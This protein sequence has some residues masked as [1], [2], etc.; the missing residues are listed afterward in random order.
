[1][2]FGSRWIS[3]AEHSRSSFALVVS[4][5]CRWGSSTSFQ[6]CQWGLSVGDPDW[7][8]LGSL[9][10][11]VGVGHQRKPTLF[12]GEERVVD[13]ERLLLLQKLCVIFWI[14]SFELPSPVVTQKNIRKRLRTWPNIWLLEPLLWWSI[15][16]RGCEDLIKTQPFWYSRAWFGGRM[17]YVWVV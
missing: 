1:V 12:Y 14:W 10:G 4:F 7:W 5:V 16:D 3:L 8:G 13:R 17:Y 2:T 11:L 15:G 9:L 6:R